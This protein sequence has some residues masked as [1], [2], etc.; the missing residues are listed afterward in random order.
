MR[1]P[2]RTAAEGADIIAVD[3]AGKLPSCVPY[4]SATPDDLAET[5]RLV[6]H[7]GRRILPLWSPIC[8]GEAIRK[9][10]SWPEMMVRAALMHLLWRQHFTVDLA[11]PLTRDHVLG[12]REYRSCSRRRGGTRFL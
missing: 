9:A 11:R 6:E 1:T 2:S 8:S 7:T 3:V 12:Q 5:V 4:R 10:R